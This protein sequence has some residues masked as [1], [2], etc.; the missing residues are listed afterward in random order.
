MD[1]M[2][3]K[4][5]DRHFGWRSCIHFDKKLAKIKKERKQEGDKGRP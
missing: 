1:D 3:K 5:E 2:F 4:I